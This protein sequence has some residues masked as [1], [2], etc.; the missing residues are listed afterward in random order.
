MLPLPLRMPPDKHAGTHMHT[1]TYPQECT[2]TSAGMCAYTHKCRHM[3]PSFMKMSTW[4]FLE[5]CDSFQNNQWQ[6]RKGGGGLRRIGRSELMRVSWFCRLLC[7]DKATYCVYCTAMVYEDSNMSI[8]FSWK[9]W[10]HKKNCFVIMP[11][12][13]QGLNQHKLSKICRP[14]AYRN[15]KLFVLK[16]NNR[17]HCNQWSFWFEMKPLL[18]T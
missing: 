11:Y 6:T 2:H 18:L 15:K 8:S 10:Q 16:Q 13:I 3:H 12:C 17:S 7:T 14:S 5:I 4:A 9:L 1:L